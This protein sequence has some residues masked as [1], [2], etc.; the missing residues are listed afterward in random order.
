MLIINL[1]STEFGAV[2]KYPSPS[3]LI[4][5]CTLVRAETEAFLDP[6]PVPERLSSVIWMSP[7]VQLPDMDFGKSA[8]MKT[9]KC[10][11]CQNERS[12]AFCESYGQLRM[13]LD[14]SCCY[15]SAL[16]TLRKDISNRF[17]LVKRAA[18]CPKLVVFGK[19]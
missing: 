11:G 5:W 13:W 4:R 10:C 18:G 2:R 12:R 7:I 16:W 15:F 17:E 19:Y 8:L 9:Y 3:V 6:D 14:L 1:L